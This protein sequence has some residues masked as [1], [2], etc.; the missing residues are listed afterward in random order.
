MIHFSVGLTSYFTHRSLPTLLIQPSTWYTEQ[1]IH[2]IHEKADRIDTARKL[3]IG[4]S[5]KTIRYDHCVLATG[6]E[7]FMPPIPG[8]EMEG[9]FVYRTV[10]DLERIIERAEGRKAGVVIGGG[11]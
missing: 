6:S 11:E 8:K 2:V 1:N 7:A 3:V 10:K 5:G 4:E 9:V